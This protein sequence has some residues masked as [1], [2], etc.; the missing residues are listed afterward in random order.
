MI[1]ERLL[2][3]FFRVQ[4]GVDQIEEQIWEV[5]DLEEDT[6]EHWLKRRK[7]IDFASIIEDLI[8]A[9]VNEGKY[10]K[11][12]SKKHLLWLSNQIFSFKDDKN[13]HV[14]FYPKYFSKYKDFRRSDSFHQFVSFFGI[15]T[16][17][18]LVYNLFVENS[19]DLSHG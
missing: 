13:S 5:E 3:K 19:I 18:G 14:F 1:D 11:R 7:N 12:Y 17:K 15:S 2:E 8:M 9:P 6:I 10:T 16:P 4:F